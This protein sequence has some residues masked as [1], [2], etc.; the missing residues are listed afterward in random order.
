M[1]DDYIAVPT[2]RLLDKDVVELKD[3]IGLEGKLTLASLMKRND[4]CVTLANDSFKH[5]A[6]ANEQAREH[7]QTAQM[8][9]IM[10]EACKRLVG[11]VLAGKSENCSM[12]IVRNDP[13]R[14]QNA[15]DKIL[16]K[17]LG[18]ENDA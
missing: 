5:Y 8:A 14:I 10:S 13:S 16:N 3:L 11:H 6:K 18:D 1:N 9:I 15:L 17:T 2:K 12:V 7:K 4:A